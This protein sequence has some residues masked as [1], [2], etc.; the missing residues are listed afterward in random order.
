MW[1]ARKNSGWGVS[2]TTSELSASTPTS[3]R[4]QPRTRGNGAERWNKGTEYFM[5]KWIAAEKAKA[6]LRHTIVCPNGTGST[7]KRIAQSKRAR[8]GSLALLS[9]HKWR[10]LVSSGRLACRCHDVFLWCYVCFILLRFRLYALVEAAPLRSIVL[11][12]VGAPIATRVSSF[13]SFCLFGDVAFSEYFLYHSRVLF[14]EYVVRSFLSNGVFLPCG[15]GL[16]F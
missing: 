12:Y 11:R 7:K 16:N 1:G 3:G 6:G 2:W 8:A 9:S 14:G 13:F 15:H 4:L 5:V 10:E